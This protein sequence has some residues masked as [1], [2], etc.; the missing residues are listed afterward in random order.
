MNTQAASQFQDPSRSQDPS[1][2]PDPPQFHASSWAP[3]DRAGIVALVGRPPERPIDADIVIPVYDEQEELAQSVTTLLRYLTATDGLPSP[4]GGFVWRIIIADNASRDQTWPIACRL[5]QDHPGQIQAARIA[6]KGRGNAL[7]AMWGRS[8]A[9]AQMYMDVDLSTDITLTRPLLATVLT[10]EADVAIGSR[11]LDDSA[12]TRSIRRELISRSYNEM[13]RSL[14]G[15][16][17]SDAQCGFKAISSTAR[18]RLLGRIED[19]E[20]FFDTELLLRAQYSGLRIGELPVRWV[21]DPGSTVNIPDT[22]RK[23]LLGMLRMRRE[24][25]RSAARSAASADRQRSRFQRA[26]A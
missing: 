5:A 14:L 16:G 1:G 13:L 24:I 6:R 21:E 9:R 19:D 11:L 15:A 4:L 22:V 12:V 10:G 8:P 3:S 20:W 25:A 2:F 23:D 26:L 7:K 18:D 17:F